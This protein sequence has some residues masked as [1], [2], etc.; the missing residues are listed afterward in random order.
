M[1]S[2]TGIER[3]GNILQHKPVDR[4]GLF[5]HFWGDTHREWTEQGHLREDENL[6]DHFGFDMDLCWPF[7][8]VADLDFEPQVIEETEETILTR[9]GNGALLAPAQA[10]RLHAGAR[11]FPGQGPARL[12]GA[13]Q[14]ELVAGPAPHQFRGLP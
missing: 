13:Y 1:Q 8:M 2:I 14:A 11:R 9:D 12:G 6:S 5:E 10:A 4:I 7:N 3:I